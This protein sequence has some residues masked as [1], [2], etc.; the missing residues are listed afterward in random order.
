M[1]AKNQ[2]AICRNRN[3]LEEVLPLKGPY[4]L[5]IDSCNLCNFKCRFE[6]ADIILTRLGQ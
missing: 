6:Y 4:S 1:K 2:N 5:V 3:K